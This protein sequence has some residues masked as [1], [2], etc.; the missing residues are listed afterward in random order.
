MKSVFRHVRLLYGYYLYGKISFFNQKLSLINQY[1]TKLI[2]EAQ[3]KHRLT[4][5]GVPLYPVT[6]KVWNLVKT[7]DKRRGDLL[8]RVN[9]NIIQLLVCNK[10]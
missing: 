5:N 9:E 6:K 10:W 2:S 7:L 8:G 4:G 1:G 3:Q